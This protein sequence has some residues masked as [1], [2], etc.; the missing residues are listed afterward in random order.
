VETHL[1]C[2]PQES[3]PDL[4]PTRQSLLSRLK[5][6]N[7]Q[8]GWQVFF[9]T[10]WKL[11]YNTALKA[12]LTEAESQDVVQ[13]TVIAVL[14]K[15]P[16]FKYDA[17]KGSFKGWLLRLTSWRITDQLRRRQKDIARLQR[18]EDTST[19]TDAI[20]RIPDPGPQLEASWDEEWE[21][22]LLNAAID[23][24]KKKVDAK[25]YQ[26]YDLYVLK[27]WPVARVARALNVSAGRVYLAKHRISHLVKKELSYLQNKPI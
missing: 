27:N 3:A 19:G 12:G 20:E 24:V 26:V 15:M 5:D 17:D 14:K 16:A 23:R 2:T 11:I 8:E 1:R 21:H 25:Q 4:L 10:Y 6:W 13:D 22:N 18:Q 7:D 9:D